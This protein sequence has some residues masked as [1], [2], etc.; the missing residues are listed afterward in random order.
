MLTNEFEGTKLKCHP[1][2]MRSSGGGV[3]GAGV[4]ASP[5]SAV[6]F[7]RMEVEVDELKES[8][9]WKVRSIRLKRK[10]EK[11]TRFIRHF[12]FTSWPD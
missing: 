4:D 12:Q 9:A 6:Q 2:W 5:D 1:Y 7:G 10:G 11:E 3:A 8:T